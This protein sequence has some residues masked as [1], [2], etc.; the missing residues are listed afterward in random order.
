MPSR[1]C[2]DVQQLLPEEWQVA[3]GLGDVPGLERLAWPRSPDVE[4]IIQ[5][6]IIYYYSMIYYNLNISV[7]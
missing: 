1:S 3:R 7:I 2:R 6:S 4:D 5:H